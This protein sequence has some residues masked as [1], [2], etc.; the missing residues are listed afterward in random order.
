MD[1]LDYE[2]EDKCDGT[3]LECYPVEDESDQEWVG[4]RYLGPGTAVYRKVS[5][6]V[7]PVDG[8][9]AAAQQH[10]I[11]YWNINRGVESGEITLKE[12]Y[13]LVDKADWRL[14]NSAF[15]DMGKRGLNMLPDIVKA[16]GG[17]DPV[18]VIVSALKALPSTLTSEAMRMKW[19][20]SK[21]GIGRGSF[22]KTSGL[23]PTAQELFDRWYNEYRDT[24]RGAHPSQSLMDYMN[25]YIFS[26]YPKRRAWRRKVSNKN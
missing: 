25:N 10:D 24:N 16:V 7:E 4:Y 18:G 1:K 11:D 14:A 6:G 22:F 26:L 19:L 13:D 8:L 2:L 23:K 20:L 9:D 12:A 21:L 5:T 3:P 17:A 15:V